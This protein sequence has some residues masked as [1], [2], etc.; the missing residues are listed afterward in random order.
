M[1]L[2][3]PVGDAADFLGRS[4]DQRLEVGVVAAGAEQIGAGHAQIG[5]LAGPRPL[6]SPDAG[7]LGL[8]ADPQPIPAFARAGSGTRFPWVCRAVVGCGSPR[9]SARRSSTRLQPRRILP[10]QP[11]LDSRDRQQQPHRVAVPRRLGRPAR[12]RR[13]PVRPQP[14]V[15]MTTPSAISRVNHPSQPRGIP[16]VT[17]SGGRY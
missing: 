16:R 17:V 3:P 9:S 13:I 5:D 10:A 6:A 12:P 4:A 1:P 8:L 7:A 11:L 14:D 15:A 2:R